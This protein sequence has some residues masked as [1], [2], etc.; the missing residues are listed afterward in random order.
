MYIYSVEQ[1]DIRGEKRLLSIVIPVF[2]ESENIQALYEE[3]IGVCK[4]FTYFNQF[5]FVFVDDGSSDGSFGLVEQLAKKDFRVRGISFVRNFG[6][7]Y[8]TSVGLCLAR[9]EAAV[10]IDG[11]RQDPAELML[12]FEQEF[13]Q[14][15]DIV[16]GQR[17]KRL[18]ETFLK[19]LTS[20]LFY[21]LFRRVS[22]VDIPPD[23]GD[24]CMLSRRVIEVFKALP[25]KRR[26]VRG[27]IYWTGFPKKGINF[28]RR[29][30]AGGV[31][32]YNYLKLTIFAL[33]NIVSFS[34]FPMYFLIFF[35][36]GL[37]GLCFIGVLIAL[38]LYLTGHVI[39]IGWTSLIISILFLFAMVFFALGIIGLYID[40]IL[41]QLKGRPMALIQKK[42]NVDSA[43]K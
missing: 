42:I 35:S 19:K 30:R 31:S 6:H 3:L 10:L 43:D 13:L 26:F 1:S 37:I 28:V 9:G 5:E 20:K 39:T 11:D 7:E 17:E 36:G 16:Y 34:S 25:E 29:G 12:D 32:K 4:Q 22:G 15:I 14:G 38:G 21:P 23:V 41:D 27:L 24:F 33:G 8:A 18:N 40:A 2:N